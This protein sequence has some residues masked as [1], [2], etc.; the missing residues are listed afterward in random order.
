MLM[1]KWLLTTGMIMSL[2]M[3]GACAQTDEDPAGEPGQEDIDESE[4]ISSD[5]NDTDDVENQPEESDNEETDESPDGDNGNSQNG[6]ESDETKEGDSAEENDAD[7]DEEEQT[8]VSEN[9]I[10]QLELEEDILN[11]SSIAVLV[12]KQYSLP[13]EYVPENLVTVEVPTVLPNPEIKQM[14][15][16][17]A[18]ALKEMFDAAEAEGIILHARSGYR[19]YNTQVQLFR[20]YASNHGEEAANKYSARA[21]ESEHQTGLV[22]DVTSESVNLQITSAFGATEEGQ[23]VKENAHE[24]GFIIR[25][26][27]GKSEI[28]GY[29]YEPWHLRYL[30]EE[31]A[32]DVY[33]SGLTYEEYLVERGLDIE[34]Q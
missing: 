7:T 10:P 19:S 30:G 17:A 33:E 15:Q 29:V 5:D 8:D 32:T 1:K 12:N 18:D 20:N 23:W 14:R 26:P 11:P 21:G 2:T 34:I 13:E 24:F 27:E 6:E 28:T 16:V 25:Y 4:Q 31:L 9:E 3:L 22:M